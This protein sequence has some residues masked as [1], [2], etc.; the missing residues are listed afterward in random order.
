MF[1]HT[2][3]IFICNILILVIVFIGSFFIGNFIG[4][5]VKFA[6]K[7]LKRKLF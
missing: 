6:L 1:N 7:N 2:N 3:F 5:F 4:N